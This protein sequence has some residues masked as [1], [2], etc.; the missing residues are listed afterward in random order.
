MQEDVP[1][2]NGRDAVTFWN[3]EYASGEG[4]AALFCFQVNC[5]K[6]MFETG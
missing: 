4:A 2:G 6:V 3:Q 5:C 1:A